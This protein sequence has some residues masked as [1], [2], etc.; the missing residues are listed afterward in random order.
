MTTYESAVEGITAALQGINPNVHRVD[1]FDPTKAESYSKYGS[2]KDEEVKASY[3]AMMTKSAERLTK[4]AGNVKALKRSANFLNKVVESQNIVYKPNVESELER[5]E[6]IKKRHD[7]LIAGHFGQQRTYELIKRD[8]Y[9]PNMLI[10]IQKYI[11]SC[12]ICQK[13]KS[14]RKKPNGKLMP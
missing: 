12:S 9:W 10:D 5:K 14:S 11:N 7:R 4:A 3:F 6:I 2:F 13:I 8:F 1:S